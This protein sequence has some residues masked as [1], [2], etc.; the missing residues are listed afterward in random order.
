MGSRKV[1]KSERRMVKIES[2]VLPVFYFP[3]FGLPHYS[4][5]TTM[6]LTYWL[7]A[8]ILLSVMIVSV[9]AKKLTPMAS[10]VGGIIG[11]C[12]YM[13][14][15]FTG[16]AMMGAFFILGTIATSLGIK[17]KIEK[18]MAEENNGQ[19]KATQ[20]IANAG[21]AALL[22]LCIHFLPKHTLPLRLMMA[23]SFSSATAD[24]LSS[25]LG[26]LWGRRFYNIL[27]FKKDE[28]GLDG[29]VSLE[30][31]GAGVCGSFVIA[32]IFM[33]G[34]GWKVWFCLIIVLSGTIGNFSDSL[35]GAALERK[36]YL[37]NDAVNF[38][39]TLIAAVVAL[40]LYEI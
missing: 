36:G 8:F 5:F 2:F 17:T 22:G 10:L 31:T 3:T 39:N 23:A 4:I 12:V 40:V 28:R 37:K 18:R 32:L 33:I 27:S 7:L 15:G 1:S 35:L 21:V 20:V 26:N 9:A 24:T 34:F 38:L 11:V 13:G 25:E 30:G 16:I 6:N 29:V 19:R 14:A